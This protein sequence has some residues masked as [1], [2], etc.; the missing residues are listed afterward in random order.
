MNFH[1]F[2]FQ[3]RPTHSSFAPVRPFT[4]SRLWEASG[5]GLRRSTYWPGNSRFLCFVVVV[6]L[7]V[8]FF[9]FV[10]FFSPQ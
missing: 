6:V 9:C 2:Y 4:S 1:I 7:L 10:L 5:V 8:Y 3:I